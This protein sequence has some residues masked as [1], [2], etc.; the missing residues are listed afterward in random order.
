MSDGSFH[1]IVAGIGGGGPPPTTI[2]GLLGAYQSASSAAHNIIGL[3]SSL[4]PV[5][6][7]N[8]TGGSRITGTLFQVGDPDVTANGI[9]TVK[10]TSGGGPGPDIVIVGAS[11]SATQ[12]YSYGGVFTDTIDSLVSTTLTIGGTLATEI[13]IP[14]TELFLSGVPALGSTFPQLALGSYTSSPAVTEFDGQ[15][16]FTGTFSPS[17]NAPSYAMLWLN[18]TVNGTST[19]KATALAITSHTNTLTG[20][21]IWL[22]DA[23]TTTSTYTSGYTQTFAVSTAGDV[24]SR[25]RFANGTATVAGDYALNASW[26]S[27]ASVTV[28]SRSNDSRGRILVTCGGAGIAANP[29]ITFTFK[30]GTWTN[31]PFCLVSLSDGTG[32]FTSPTWTTTATTLVITLPA[33]PITGL[34]YQFDYWTV[35]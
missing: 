33:T 32:A 30:D 19:G 5:I 4:G 13:A 25:R 21:T 35:G 6:I 7:N 10:G 22:I 15:A 18:P 16:Q 27:T 14:N 31:A 34:T 3:T 26:G 23:G 28:T 29:T 24:T 11:D 9:L 2:D 12:F 20:G 8:N 1:D 17:A